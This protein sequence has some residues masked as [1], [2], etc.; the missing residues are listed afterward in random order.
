MAVHDEADV[1]SYN[2]EWY[3]TAGF[4]TVALIDEHSSDRSRQICEKA[5]Y[6]G[7]IIALDSIAT[8]GHE[9][10]RTL[11]RLLELAEQAHPEFLIL[12]APD[13]FFE[14]ADGAPLRAALE[15]D[16]KA[17][18]NLIQFSNMEFAMTR[19]DN[20]GDPNPLTRMRHYALN[21]QSNYRAFPYIRG[22]DP[23]DGHRPRF[24]KSVKDHPSP[25]RYISRHYPLRTVGQ[26]LAKIRRMRPLKHTP[27]RTTHY[28]RFSG[29]DV[30][31]LFVDPTHLSCYAE[32]HRW[33][34]EER[35]LKT[36]LAQT[37]YALARAEI[38]GRQL[39]EKLEEVRSENA[40]LRGKLRQDELVTG[41]S[42]SA[43]PDAQL[44][45]VQRGLR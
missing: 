9:W 2:L 41:A 21:D 36:Q 13:E 22:I 17:G 3:R 35:F 37:V 24:P 11:S 38:E 8:D 18:Y 25:R 6:N 10:G 42:D 20:P 34:Y 12:T 45:T 27:Y 23:H 16:F 7:T 19:E 31:E 26:A 40:A 30:D 5:L 4:P 33:C 14:V 28:L 44:T 15:E 39:R 32:D 1:L 29:H 43:T